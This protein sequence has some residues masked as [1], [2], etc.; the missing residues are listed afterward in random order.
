MLAAFVTVP[1]YNSVSLLQYVQEIKTLV[2]F[3]SA[4]SGSFLQSRK[5]NVNNCTLTDWLT[6]LLIF[7]ISLYTSIYITFFLLDLQNRF[8]QVTLYAQAFQKWRCHHDSY[9]SQS[10]ADLI[11]CRALKLTEAFWCESFT[12]TT[13]KSVWCHC[14]CFWCIS[15]QCIVCHDVLYKKS[16]SLKHQLW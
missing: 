3:E 16:R 7:Q 2:L 10:T 12:W 14:S 8:H 15:S 9:S 1:K 4:W 13:T 5:S 11:G 6:M